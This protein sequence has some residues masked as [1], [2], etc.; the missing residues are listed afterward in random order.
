MRQG[1]QPRRDAFNEH[2]TVT[3]DIETIV[4]AAAEPADGSFPPWPRHKPV[5]AAFLTSRWTPKNFEFQVDTLICRPGREA[6][7]YQKVDA[8]LPLGA[9]GI[10]FNGRGFDNRVLALQA[11]LH[12]PDLNLPDLARQALAARFDGAHRDLADVYSGF[13]GT[14]PVAL[15]EICRALGIPIKTTISGGD[16]GALWREGAYQQVLDYVSED[17]CAT[18]IAHLISMAFERSDE[19]LLT[20]PLAELAAWIESEPALACLHH[21]ASCR[22]ATVARVRA[23]ALRAEAALAD[24]ERRLAQQR[25]EQAFAASGR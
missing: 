14:R 15:A 12:C 16:V 17:V 2:Y 7:F 10:T 3:Y 18:H 23:P 24:A 22:P 6:E 9:S 11:S 1:Q 13:G 21:F 19:K 20:L 8:L 25:D 4:D 5:A